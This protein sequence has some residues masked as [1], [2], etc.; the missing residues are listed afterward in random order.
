[1]VSNPQFKKVLTASLA[2]FLTVSLSTANAEK[3]R[4]G[5]PKGKPPEA[6]FTACA[7]QT[8][9]GSACSF[10]RPDGESIEGTCK[11]P[12]RS[13]ESLVCAPNR[14]KHKARPAK[15]EID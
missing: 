2:L 8:E 4:K 6:A 7:N 5:P 11:V 14:G 13:E 15:R 3:G 10:N 1:M 9:E 12:R